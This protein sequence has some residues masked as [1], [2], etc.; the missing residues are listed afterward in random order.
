MG[1]VTRGLF[2]RSS[3]VAGYSA[4]RPVWIVEFQWRS[5]FYN[6]S[7]MLPRVSAIIPSYNSSA[8]IRESVRSVLLQ[9]Y[10]AIETIVV[11][12]GSHDSTLDILREFGGDIR[13]LQREHTSIGSARNAGIDIAQGEYIAFLD[14]DDL[15]MPDKISRQVEFMLRNPRCCMLYTDA[16]EFRGR[17]TDLK[18]F[19]CKFPS[20]SSNTN[21]AESMVLDWAVPLTSTVIVRRDFLRQH[22]ICFHP[23]ASCAEDLSMF[24]EIYIHGGQILSLNE[25]LVRRRIHGNNTSGDHYNRFFQRLAVYGDLLRRFPDAPSQTRKLIQ[26]GLREANFCVADRHWGELELAK[27][28]TYFRRAIALDTVGVKSAGFW[29]LTFAPKTIISTLKNLKQRGRGAMEPSES[30]AVGSDSLQGQGRAR[31]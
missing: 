20:L 21:I 7:Q 9:T 5:L 16:Q 30:R 10:S 14:S 31:D 4:N 6:R 17:D 29:V 28:R 2:L 25:T 15:W 12:D 18:S 8:W 27:S 3:R 22:G 1:R 19:F 26:A 13:V 11:D 23:A 24:L